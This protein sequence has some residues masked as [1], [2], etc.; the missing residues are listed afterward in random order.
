VEKKRKRDTY[1]DKHEEL[2]ELAAKDELT[3]M[4][5]QLHP[6]TAEFDV[7]ELFSS[8]GKVKD[9]R[10]IQDERSGKCV[11]VGY[12]E[13]ATRQ[14]LVQALALDGTVLRGMPMV[15]QVSFAEKNRLAATGASAAE[16][17]AVGLSSN[18]PGGS[19]ASEAG[20]KL[21]VGNL[22]PSLSE[23]QL[24]GVFAPFGQLDRVDVHKTPTG[25]S[26]GFAFLH[27]AFAAD[28]RKCMAQMDGFSLA[29]RPIRVSLSG[30]DHSSGPHSSGGGG[31]GGRD[32]SIEKLDSLD[33]GSGGSKVTAA[34]RAQMMAR[35]AE[36]SGVFV[37][38]ELRTAAAGAAAYGADLET[39]RCVVL[40]NMFDRLSPEATSNPNFFSEIAEDVR[41]EVSKLGT[42]IHCAADK[43]S[44]GFVYCKLLAHQEAARVRAA[45]HGR[46]F[47]K[48][49]II[50][51]YVEESVYDKKNK[52]KRS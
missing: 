17:K 46:Y 50:C 23:D 11:G 8:V 48:N 21:Y 12:V 45:M 19:N 38:S 20:M 10:L 51:E 28:G 13:M 42:V 43:W 37:P 29:G 30:Q 5:R 22:H 41:S 2:E 16:I 47:A 36:K 35:L 3:L 7:F 44:N 14:D 31:R 52:L 26:K 49:R 25:E 34:Q 6:R 40:K 32:S 9:V 4:V 18:G 33:E 24:R 1:Y 15:V 27:F 39:S